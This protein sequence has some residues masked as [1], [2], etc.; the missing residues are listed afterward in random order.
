MKKNKDLNVKRLRTIFFLV[1]FACNLSSYALAPKNNNG[2]RVANLETNYWVIEAIDLF[3]T[4]VM[5]VAF[6][7]TN[8][9][10]KQVEDGQQVLGIIFALFNPGTEQIKIRR[11]DFSVNGSQID[12]YIVQEKNTQPLVV[13]VPAG[14]AIAITNYYI[15]DSVI[16]KIE[17]LK[18][19]YSS[20]DKSYKKI[21]IEIPLLQEK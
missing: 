12:H 16:S 7:H 5:K 9:G 21:Q 15:V 13:P 11:N 10:T 18:V 1:L 14:E 4:K 6:N 3:N 20:V 19:I 17:D 8:S 2:V